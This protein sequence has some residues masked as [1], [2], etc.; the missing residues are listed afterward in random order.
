M[1][2]GLTW[3]T[4]IYTVML[5]RCFSLFSDPEDP[6]AAKDK[7]QNAALCKGIPT[8]DL[9]IGRLQNGPHLAGLKGF[10]RACTG[11]DRTGRVRRRGWRLDAFESFDEIRRVAVESHMARSVR[12]PRRLR[13]PRGDK[14]PV[15]LRGK[16]VLKVNS[17]TT[18][19][20][21]HHD[22]IDADRPKHDYIFRTFS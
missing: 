4:V 17:L 18:T 13:K 10:V 11:A 6:I 1:Q 14:T 19:I 7:I 16:A 22:G 12:R 20:G 9:R 15:G 8:P 3:N 5:L 21:W 2:I